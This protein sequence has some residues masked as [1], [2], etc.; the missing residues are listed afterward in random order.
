MIVL[1]FFSTVWSTNTDLEFKF[2]FLETRKNT[3]RY[4]L[5]CFSST[6]QTCNICEIP[7]LSLCSLWLVWTEPKEIGPAEPAEC[8]TAAA[9][10]S[11]GKTLCPDKLTATSRLVTLKRETIKLDSQEDKKII[12][13]TAFSMEYANYCKLCLCHITDIFQNIPLASA[14][15][16]SLQ[17]RQQ[18]P[19]ILQR[20]GCN[21]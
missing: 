6:E 13:L 16:F 12:T 7:Y 5:K 21:S 10:S 2:K 3:F 15:N 17:G 4:L 8:T 18:F 19:L 9:G 1:S 20:E 14:L 11:G